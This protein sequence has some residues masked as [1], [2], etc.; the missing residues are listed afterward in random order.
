MRLR[1]FLNE[2]SMKAGTQIRDYKDGDTLT[3]VITLSTGDEFQLLIGP[4][5]MDLHNGRKIE[6]YEILF[7]DSEGNIKTSKKSPKV[8]IELFAAIEKIITSFIVRHKPPV[9]AFAAPKP[10]STSSEASK[11]KLY[12]LLAKKVAKGGKYILLTKDN[13]IGKYVD[14]DTEHLV[15]KEVY[16]RH[17]KPTV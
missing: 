9:I 1:Q 6:R 2:L 15:R 3:W 10:S 7:V 13:H 5:W 14:M 11:K 4:D 16:E 17:K 8:A 12:K